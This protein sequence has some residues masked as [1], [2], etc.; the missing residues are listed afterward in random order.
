[1]SDRPEI[2][3]GTYEVIRQRLLD[4]AANLHSKTTALNENA[5]ESLAAPNRS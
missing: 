5:K 1:M 2:A 4:Q 3:S